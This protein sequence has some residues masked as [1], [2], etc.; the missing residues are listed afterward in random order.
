MNSLGFISTA[1]I[2]PYLAAAR[3]AGVDSAAALRA[4]GIQ[5]RTLEHPDLQIPGDRFEAL[6]AAV[7]QTHLTLPTNREV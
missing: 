3:Q 1:G 4:V 7:S 6:I 2:H 5:P